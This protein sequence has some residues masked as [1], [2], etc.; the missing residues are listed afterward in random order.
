MPK[1]A[2]DSVLSELRGRKKSI[3]RS[4]LIYLLRSLGFD[5]V[6]GNKGKHFTY[7]HPGFSVFPAGTF[8]GGHGK[9]DVIKFPYI[10]DAIGLL[11]RYENELRELA[12]ETS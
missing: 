3:K 10:L 5:V 1:S 8:N 6:A 2:Y 12:G 7:V 11:E 9:D 4:E